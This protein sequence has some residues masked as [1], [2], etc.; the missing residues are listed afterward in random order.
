MMDSYLTIKNLK[1]GFQSYSGLNRVVDIDD[2]T[3]E[4]GQAFALVGESGSGKSVTAFA[5]QQLLTV[6][7]AVI[8][9][10]ELTLDGI[11]I[12]DKSQK[13]MTDIR[14]RKIAMIFQDPMS[15]LNPVFTVGEQITQAVRRN[16]KLGRQEARK[17]AIELIETVKLPDAERILSKYPH[18]L[19]GG[20]R[21]R[22]IIAIAL[23]C[24]AEFL[25]ADEPT[26]NLDVTIQAGILKLL[27]TL[28]REEKLTVLFIT[29][30]LS[31]VPLLCDQTALLYKGQV[32]ECGTVAEVIDGHC[33]PYTE[34]LIQPLPVTE[35]EKEAVKT[36]TAEEIPVERG[37]LFQNK[38]RFCTP[39]CREQAPEV[40][41]LSPTHKVRCH[42]YQEGVREQW[43]NQ[44]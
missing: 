2:L 1:V 15:T 8:S 43:A 3:I 30:N 29:N 13:E 11:Q 12:L 34:A 19:S 4:R 10:D 39:L 23:G 21:Q 38:C 16:R 33:H 42:R 25:I 20:Q 35:E 37:C 24:G 32:M 9:A 31:L 22:I 14:G 40:V 27:A 28:Q 26:R 6:P 18:E 44:S 41:S 36:A 7:P 17:R 5:L